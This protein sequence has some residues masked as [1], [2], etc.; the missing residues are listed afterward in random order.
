[1]S[2]ERVLFPARHSG[3]MMQHTLFPVTVEEFVAEMGVSQDEM[4]RWYAAGWLS[5]DP[6]TSRI[7]DEA[8][9]VEVLFMRALVRFGFS[10]AMINRLLAGLEKP[11]CYNPRETFYSFSR[12][13]WVTVA[14]APALA[15]LAA[16]GIEAMIQEEQWSEL[17]AIKDRIE[18]VMKD[19]ESESQ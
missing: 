1:M 18:K 15:D 8:E 2:D 4:R 14:P 16:D 19:H 13:G 3:A 11:Y 5:F 9:R 6:N 17:E 10:D 12:Q 7:Y